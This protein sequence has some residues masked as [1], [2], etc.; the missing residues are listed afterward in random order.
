LNHLRYF[1]LQ[2]QFAELE[3]A[4]AEP[5]SLSAS[6]EEASVAAGIAQF[7]RLELFFTR[8]R[9]LDVQR[10]IDL[11]EKLLSGPHSL[12]HDEV[13]QVLSILY[14]QRATL[15]FQTGDHGG[16]RADQQR[17]FQ[18]FSDSR[19]PTTGRLVLETPAPFREYLRSL[20][21]ASKY[22]SITMS[23]PKLSEL[24]RFAADLGSERDVRHLTYLVDVF[25]LAKDLPI[26]GLE[27]PYTILT[28]VLESEGYA[29][30]M[31]HAKL[32][33][34]RRRWWALHMLLEEDPWYE[35]LRGDL[36]YWREIA[37]FNEIRELNRTLLQLQ[38]RLPPQRRRPLEEILAEPA[39]PR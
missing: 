18:L 4:L 16:A 10:G 35:A 12:G 13:R 39:K 5:I 1:R 32:V 38:D 19:Q 17:S 30:A 28:A 22:E 14:Q 3:R 9:E 20:S 27:E 11:G 21:L 23:V 34:L 36:A 15:R 37:M 2:N 6:R 26:S 25:L 29:T 7:L 24:L 8:S 33:P 31:D